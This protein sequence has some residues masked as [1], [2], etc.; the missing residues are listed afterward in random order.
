MEV[1][2]GSIRVRPNE[3]LSLDAARGDLVITWPQ[4][5]TYTLL[6]YDLDVPARSPYIHFW[7]SNIPGNDLEHG[8][9]RI[10]YT[11]P[12]PPEGA[13]T[14]LIDL[15]RQT[16]MLPKRGIDLA[17]TPR[18]NFPLE[19]VVRNHGLEIVERVLFRVTT[20]PQTRSRTAALAIPTLTVPALAGTQYTGIVG[21]TMDARGGYGMTTTDR[22]GYGVTT[23]DRGGYGTTTTGAGYGMTTS[24]DTR[25]WV[26]GLDE[27]SATYCR[28]VLHVA[29]KEPVSCLTDKAWYQQREGHTCA[30]PYAVAHKTVPGVTRIEC[31]N[32]YDFDRM[33]DA[34]LVAFANLNA[35][36][37]PVGADRQAVIQTIKQKIAVKEG[38]RA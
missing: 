18:E 12:A 4:E 33:P 35:I 38:A 7:E 20:G 3:V 9:V 36:Q 23:T 31:H 37:L 8:D 26:Q 13:H 22:G 21:P 5:G 19:A 29:A 17:A 27:Q 1:K 14:Y 16:R 11:P 2:F 6:V 28:A 25:D 10:P 34:E 30:N 32:Y 15:Y 24:G